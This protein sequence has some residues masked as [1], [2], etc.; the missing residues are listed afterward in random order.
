M[1]SS[2]RVP[3][4]G[5]LVDLVIE[6]NDRFTDAGVRHGFGGAIALAYYVAEP[7][8]TR[9]MDINVSV[10]IAQTRSIFELLPS[11]VAWR[12]ADVRR[13]RK[14]GQIRLWY[15]GSKDG[16]A[17]DL[18]FPQHHFHDRVAELTSPRL[19]ARR[20]YL[21]PVIA[22]AHLVV[23]KALFNRTKDWV[24]IESMLRAGSVDIPEALHWLQRL[25]GADDPLT[26]RLVSLIAD[27]P[28]V[29]TGER[30]RSEMP[31]VDWRS[32]RSG[33]P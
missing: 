28:S 5:S 22:A 15:G 14:D 19:F 21:I 27:V 16:Y 2:D 23:F 32:L 17:I 1:S 18:F 13:C 10:P 4:H 11:G 31:V 9:D 24:D 7:R 8:A 6:V 33:G 26:T 20:D 25:L 30:P 12:D 3:D 29:R